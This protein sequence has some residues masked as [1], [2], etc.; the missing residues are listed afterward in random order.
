MVDI[1]KRLN[2]L[3]SQRKSPLLL[4]P[5][6]A[7]LFLK[8]LHTC[9]ARRMAGKHWGLTAAGRVAMCLL[10]GGM[11]FVSTSCMSNGVSDGQAIEIESSPK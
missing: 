2:N 7:A 5:S 6:N 3:R 1:R 11:V 9:L 4:L 8:G 10:L